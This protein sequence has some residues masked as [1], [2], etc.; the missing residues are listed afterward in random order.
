MMV[1][2]REWDTTADF[3][4]STYTADCTV[5]YLNIQ[6][7]ELIKIQFY[8]K[9]LIWKQNMAK[10]IWGCEQKSELKFQGQW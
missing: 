7:E 10:V 4:N 8:R 1:D 5:D 3:T 6:L 2:V 9:S